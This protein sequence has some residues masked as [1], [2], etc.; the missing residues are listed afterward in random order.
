MKRS[1]GEKGTTGEKRNITRMGLSPPS[2]KEEDKTQKHGRTIRGG[3]SLSLSLSSPA[4][5]APT[6]VLLN[7]T[8]NDAERQG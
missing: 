6:N 1:T 8:N 5:P 2:S 4:V 7:A 3:L